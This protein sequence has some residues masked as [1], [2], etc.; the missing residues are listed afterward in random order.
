MTSAMPEKIAN[1]ARDGRNLTDAS[2][3]L[4]ILSYDLEI[5]LPWHASAVPTALPERARAVEGPRV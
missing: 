4:V 1:V 3:D 2:S 5:E